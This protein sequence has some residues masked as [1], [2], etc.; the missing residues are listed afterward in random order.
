[1]TIIRAT[2]TISFD[3]EVEEGLV[4]SEDEALDDIAQHLDSYASSGDFE[5]K[6]ETIS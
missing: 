2:A 6:V 5:Y 4:T 1:M 3:Y